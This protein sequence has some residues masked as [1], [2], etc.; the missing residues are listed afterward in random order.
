MKIVAVLILPLFALPVVAVAQ[1]SPTNTPTIR[2]LTWLAD[3]KN[4]AGKAMFAATLADPQKLLEIK[5]LSEKPNYAGNAF[6]K[7]RP[8][9]WL[10]AAKGDAYTLTNK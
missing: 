6:E 7:V 2:A 3:K 8:L 10:A 4:L 1:D 5:T 9:L